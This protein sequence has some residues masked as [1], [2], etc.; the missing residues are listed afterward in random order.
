MYRL[1]MHSSRSTEAEEEERTLVSGTE[2]SRKPRL[3]RQ[4]RHIARCSK[5]IDGKVRHRAQ[6]VK[7]GR[8]WQR[9]F[10]SAMV[11]VATTLSRAV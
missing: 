9:R 4:A 2:A 5:T 10:L 3:T 6:K 8:S 11:V 1:S 7:G